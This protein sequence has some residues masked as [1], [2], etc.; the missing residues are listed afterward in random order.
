MVELDV[1]GKKGIKMIS[2][3]FQVLE[4][5]FEDTTELQRQLLA[6]FSFGMLTK[7]SQVKKLPIE[8]A[9]QNSRSM[10]IDVF[11]YGEDQAFE[12]TSFL[13]DVASERS[14]HSTIH[15]VIN[16]GM[17]GYVQLMENKNL[18]LKNN[19]EEILNEVAKG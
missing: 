10:L 7:M 19:I 13:I 6:A 14:V 5:R 15:V 9:Y 2:T 4:M 12:F 18:E 17:L 3:L 8:Q 16:R 11:H 1:V